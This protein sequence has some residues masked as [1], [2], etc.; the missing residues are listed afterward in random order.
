[1]LQIAGCRCLLTISADRDERERAV[2]REHDT[3][4]GQRRATLIEQC[5]GQRLMARSDGETG[6]ECPF[7][8]RHAVG[9]GR[10]I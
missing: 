10:D 9:A 1:L 4:A 6:I 2:R 7:T 3:R 8:L 5:R